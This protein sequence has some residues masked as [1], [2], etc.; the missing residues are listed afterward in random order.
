MTYKEYFLDLDKAILR[1]LI[2]R[3][4]AQKQLFEESGHFTDISFPQRV[5]AFEKEWQTLTQE[6]NT[7]LIMLSKQGKKGD[8]KILLAS[9]LEMKY[10][11][12]EMKLY[13]DKLVGNIGDGGF[14]DERD[15]VDKVCEEMNKEN[16][17]RF[18]VEAR[19]VNL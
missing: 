16:P 14:F 13:S 11:I 6:L 5:F 9:G 8:D 1:A 15:E 4:N 10:V 2:K 19:L 7:S 18:Y 12:M 17:G 3:N